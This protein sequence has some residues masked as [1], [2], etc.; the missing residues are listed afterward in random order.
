MKLHFILQNIERALAAIDSP[1]S[2]DAVKSY[3]NRASAELRRFRITS[4]SGVV[5]SKGNMSCPFLDYDG[6]A[7][8]YYCTLSNL[9]L[10]HRDAD[11][12]LEPQEGCTWKPCILRG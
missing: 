7:G 12:F 5:C 6:E 8:Q 10:L 3:L 9:Y 2:K 11:G 4:S 1:N